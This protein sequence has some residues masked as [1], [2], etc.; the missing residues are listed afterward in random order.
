M[1]ELR[2]TFGIE[3]LGFGAVHQSILGCYLEVQ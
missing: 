2:N 3:A 1:H